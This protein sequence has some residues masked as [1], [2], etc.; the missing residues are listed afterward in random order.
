M[1][2]HLPNSVM[3]TCQCT[4]VMNMGVITL[5]SLQKCSVIADFFPSMP[6]LKYF[7]EFRQPFIKALIISKVNMHFLGNY[8]YNSALFS[9][10]TFIVAILLRGNQ[11]QI[12]KTTINICKECKQCF[13]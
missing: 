11:L 8:V 7:Y 4:C 3:A 1:L 5:N 10:F 9:K 2:F 6:T 12:K 13:I